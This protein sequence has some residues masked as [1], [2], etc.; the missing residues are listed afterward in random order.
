MREEVTTI[1]ES[2]TIIASGPLTSAPLTAEI[3]RLSGSE[4]HLYFYDAISPIVSLDSV[5]ISVA[6]RGSRYDKGVA[7][8]GD[9]LNCPLSEAE[10]NRFIEAL[11]TAETITLRQ[12]EQEDPHFFESCLPVEVFGQTK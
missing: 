4:A 7:E 2:P 6:F 9:Y 12:F 8:E 11:I 10:Y 3:A 5:D 1:P